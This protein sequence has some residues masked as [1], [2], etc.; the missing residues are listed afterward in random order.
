[1]SAVFMDR[2]VVIRTGF[3]FR[4]F[5]FSCSIRRTKRE[6]VVDAT[7]NTESFDNKGAIFLNELAAP[8]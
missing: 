8:I 7:F 2:G 6:I 4:G 1:M 3:S 5:D